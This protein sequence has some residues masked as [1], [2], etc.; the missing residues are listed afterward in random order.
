MIMG[1]L[2]TLASL[3]PKYHHHHH[4]IT[5]ITPNNWFR[6]CSISIKTK[7]RIKLIN[8]RLQPCN[9]T[10][11]LSSST[12]TPNWV[13][14]N[15]VFEE[16]ERVFV[17]VNFYRFVSIQD[18]E[19][20]VD[21]HLQFLQGRDIHGRIY[22][23]EQGINAQYSGPSEDALAYASWIKKDERFKDILV[24][25]SSPVQRH[26]FPR[27]KLRYKPSLVQM[28]GGV[29][30]LPLVDSSM[31]ATPLT[32][33][34]WREKLSNSDK[35]VV[36]LDVRNGY[37]WDIGHFNGAQR[38]NVDCFRSTTFGLSE[39][40]DVASDPLANVDKENTE[41][42]M[43]C[44]GGIRC[45]VYSTILRQKG[46]KN[47]YT[48]KGGI[49]HYLE[50][51]GPVEWI[52]NLFVF[53]SR[54]SLPPSSVK[55]DSTNDENTVFAKCYICGSQ[56]SELRHRNCANLD[57]NLLFLCCSSCMNDLRGCCT[58]KCTSADRLR[59]VLP[60][61]ERYKKWHHYRDT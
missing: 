38:P 46:Y 36:L 56:V 34:E 53:D 35:D 57:C 26:A 9:C 59:P 32:P 28:E 21:K 16:D 52:G 22:I 48:L 6:N 8:I 42:L 33:S 51:E 55:H 7:R 17:V 61:H 29:S 37:E 4:P 50:C 10:T 20:E 58:L 13:K 1:S 27:L 14:G 41:I 12:S 15:E 60:G 11:A 43:Y 3:P 25:V 19:A 45:D 30:H 18:P 2:T 23:N 44:T 5:T 39:S 24:Q 54:L 49:S 40:E 47:L 31:R